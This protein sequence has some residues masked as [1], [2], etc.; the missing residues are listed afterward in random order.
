MRHPTAFIPNTTY[1]EKY[2]HKLPLDGCTFLLGTQAL[3]CILSD[4]EPDPSYRS[5]LPRNHSYCTHFLRSKHLMTR[6]LQI[7]SLKHICCRTVDTLRYVGRDK[8]WEAA[9]HDRVLYV[10]DHGSADD[11][12]VVTA[13]I[14]HLNYHLDFDAQLDTRNNPD[15]WCSQ[16][17]PLNPRPKTC[18]QQM[19]FICQRLKIL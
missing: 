3:E 6:Q 11:L 8:R 15:I 13:E 12:T 9:V 4:V 18:D 7:D 14:S 2:I 19:L 17:E 1:D 16:L 10:A 5:I